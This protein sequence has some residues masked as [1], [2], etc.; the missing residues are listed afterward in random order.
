MKKIIQ[1]ACIWILLATTSCNKD[2]LNEEPIDF[3]SPSNAFSTTQDFNT[4]INN[5][6]S[7]VR[8]EF[9]SRDENRPF[10]YLYGTDIVFDGQP[11]TVRHT[12]MTSAYAV[13]GGIALDHWIDLY[14]IIS[15]ANTVISRLPASQIP[16][17]QKPL[18]EAKAKFFRA[19]AYRTLC[20]L[21]GGV[22]LTL[23]ELKAPKVDF[24]RAS[25]QE[26]LD[27]V[28]SDLV[29]AAANLPAINSPALLDGEISNL[30]AQHL[31]AE[32]YLAAG[33]YQ[34]AVDA[35]TI[36]IDDPNTD[37]MLNRFGSRS[38]VTP[39]NAYWDLFQPKNQ[40]R[41]AG[42][43]EALWV[44]QFETDILGGGMVSTGT[45]GSYMLERHHAPLMR[46]LRV[47]GSSPFRWP[48][49]NNT[50]G[51]GIGWAIS[52]NHFSQTIWQ[53]D[54][55]NDGRNTPY[56]FVRSWVANQGPLS[57][58]TISAQTP[59]P[60]VTVPSRPIYAY[61]AKATTPGLHPAG[62][63]SGNAAFPLELRSTAGATYLDQ[64]M[65]RLAETYLLRAEAYFRLNLPGPAAADINAVRSRSQATNV[66]AANVTIDYILDERMRE[67]G[68][69]EKRRLTLMRLGL[70]HDRVSR[71][72][73]YYSDVLP[74]FNLWPIP[75][76]EIERN[77]EA[78]L[79]Q[80]PGYPN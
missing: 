63:F 30:V 7:L 74:H 43:K 73:P 18:Y 36:V 69:E 56:N 26:V 33:Q 50:G 2:F 23:E 61:Q 28:I 3:L 39:G 38:T 35:A 62:L 4:S 21:Y 67:L 66:L 8:R 24:V 55:N 5:L 15:E 14:K 75:F 44:I 58:T 11:G 34:K 29:F 1:L 59:P 65:F 54:F 48:V 77:R 41:K 12:I 79:E 42:N 53:S 22:P 49:S 71:F 72:N 64:Y 10:D 25:K 19:L 32:V 68:V 46:D 31:L 57:G 47:N 80:N 60:G 27:Q 51:R 13:D 40:N 6:Y 9:Y 45:G 78:V 76:R 70:L 52:T 16:D 37:L 20:Y 17:N